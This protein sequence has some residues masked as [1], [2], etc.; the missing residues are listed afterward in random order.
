[1][2]WGQHVEQPNAPPAR[3][4]RRDRVPPGVIA[5]EQGEE[6][7]TTKEEEASATCTDSEQSSEG[8]DCSPQQTTRAPLSEDSHQHGLMLAAYKDVGNDFNVD[9]GRLVKGFEALRGF[10]SGP[11]E[12]AFSQTNATLIELC[13]PH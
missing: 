10:E 11:K 6:E 4:A 9:Q 3:T 7:Q 8:Q 12:M 5:P 1:M 13:G 2:Q